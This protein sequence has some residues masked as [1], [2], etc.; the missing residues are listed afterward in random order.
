MK[1]YA[2]GNL[3]MNLLSIEERSKYLDWIK[4]E[5]IGKKFE[6]TEIVLCPPFV[7]VESFKKNI[8]MKNFFVGVQN[9][10]QEEE[11]SRCHHQEY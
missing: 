11:Y 2:I 9:I 4:K 5:L 7:H 1:K 8:K 3:K 6:Q 10:F